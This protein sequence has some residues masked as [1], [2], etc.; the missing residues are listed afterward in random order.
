M[1]LRP[2]DVLD[3]R[4]DL[5]TRLD[6][7]SF[8]DIVRSV[9][10]AGV[11][12]HTVQSKQDFVMANALAQ[13]APSALAPAVNYYVSPD[14]CD[15]VA[16]AADMLDATDMADITIVPSPAGFAYFDKP[17]VIHDV[18]GD[19]VNVNAIVWRRTAN[20][21]MCWFFNDQYRHPDAAAQFVLEEEDAAALRMIGR[22]G[23]I[24]CI[25][26]ADGEQIGDPIMSVS[27]TA[28]DHYWKDRSEDPPSFDNPRRPIHA[29]WML[30]NQTLVSRDREFGDRRTAK[31]MKRMDV[32]ND[33]TVI[34]LRRREVQH[35]GEGSQVEWSHR[36]LVR[37][38]WRWQPFKNDEG[39]WDHRRQWINPYIKGPADAPLVVTQKVNAFTR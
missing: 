16:H 6:N 12:V 18:R 8:R 22:W 25:L 27:E 21:V 1:K 31:R 17:I 13:I 36:W 19:F 26:Y 28:Y 23:F 9:L 7:A 32:P 37:G 38:F 11:S 4:A 24:G 39:E 34:T 33:V 3:L 5:A 2:T 30:L 14:M 20:D 15:L 10:E 29:L 35:D